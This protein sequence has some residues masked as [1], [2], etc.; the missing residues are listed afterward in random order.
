VPRAAPRLPLRARARAGRSSAL[1]LAATLDGRIATAKANRA[2]SPDPP[3]A[4]PCTGC[5]RRTDAIWVG[6]ATALA[7]DPE[8]TA[9]ARGRVVHRPVRLVA[10]TRLRLPPSA[11]MLRGAPGQTWVLCGPDAPRAR[12]RALEAA[13]ARVLELACEGEGLDLRRALRRLG[14]EGLTEILVEGGGRLAAGCCALARGRAALVHGAARDRRDGRA[15][16]GELGVRALAAAPRLGD[17][18]L[19]RVGDDAHWDRPLRARGA[20]VCE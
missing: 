12:R 16:L 11:R 14:R 1:K 13:G 18:S 19:R 17:V 7:D 6:A 3:R 8:L 10:D 2:G 4:R 15:A 5:G 9:R 20:Q